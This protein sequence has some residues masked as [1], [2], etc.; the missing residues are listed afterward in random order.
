MLNEFSL[1]FLQLKNG[2]TPDRH[3]I[4]VQYIGP[5][6]LKEK[7]CGFQ[8]E[9]EV[10]AESTWHPVLA[11]HQLWTHQQVQFHLPIISFLGEFLLPH[12]H[13]HLPTSHNLDWLRFFIAI[14]ALN[15]NV[16]YLI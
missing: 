11:F 6:L 13:P 16:S 12:P 5:A 1:G 7:P 3:R 8:E 2:K 10:F 9:T 14:L 4:H 15:R